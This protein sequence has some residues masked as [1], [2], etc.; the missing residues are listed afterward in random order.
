MG[1]IE[2]VGLGLGKGQPLDLT[3]TKIY[4]APL[5]GHIFLVDSLFYNE[6]SWNFE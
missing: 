3:E 5:S 2:F 1:V 4:N 6:M